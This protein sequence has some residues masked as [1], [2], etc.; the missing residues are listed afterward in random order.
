[1]VK[2]KTIKPPELITTLAVVLVAPSPSPALAQC[3]PRGPSPR[4]QALSWRT[5][6]VTF[7][8]SEAKR[9]REWGEHTTI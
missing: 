7:G 3:F 6:C 5:S 4:A 2:N 8:A 1:M 9:E